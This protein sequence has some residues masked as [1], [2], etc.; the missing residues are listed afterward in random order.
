MRSTS[1]SR[2]ERAIR[3]KLKDDF[4][5]FS[6]KCLKIRTKKGDIQPFQLNKAQKYLHERAQ[7]QLKTL[8]RVRIVI[9]KGR[10]QGISTYVEGRLYWRTI[11]TK[12]VRAFILTHEQGATD[13]LFEMAQRYHELNNPIIKPHTG[14]SNAKEL[15]FDKLDSGYKVG[16][17]GSKAVGRSATIQY[18]HGS[19]VAF[20]P[21]AEEHASGVLQAVP[22][23]DGTEVFL[24]STADGIGNYYH[25]KVMQALGGDDEYELVFIPWFWEPG[26]RLPVPEG[27]ALDD[28]DTD[29]RDLHGLDN[30]QMVW[31]RDKIR[32]F[33]GDAARF[34][35][36]YPATVE[37][38]FAASSDQS[39]I[40]P[41][42]VLAARKCDAEATG[43]LIMGVDVAR[44]GDDSTVYTFRQGR[45]VETQIKKHSQDT[46][47]TAGEI[48]KLINQRNPAKVFVDVIGV[49]AGVVDRL[50]EW[51]GPKIEGI[52]SAE[53]A[54]DSEQY[55][56]RRAEMYGELREW[57]KDKPCQLPDDDR[58][59]NDLCA[60]QY[61]Y[62]SKG[63]Y[64]LE[65]KEDLKK[66]LGR[67]PDMSDS[68]VLTFAE[69]VFSADDDDA[70]PEPTSWMA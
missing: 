9:L 29:Y 23:E 67:S 13:N 46:M 65:A 45:V 40:R 21:H 7:K 3:Q 68:L 24:E 63:Q 35:R 54:L 28:E 30:E 64:Q 47:A 18:F 52:N 42:L 43:P 49:G 15:S 44:F 16:T 1:L 62:T 70:P 17:A 25:K 8:G 33:N 37:E 38:A 22:K 5:H 59:Q 69:P 27:F 56:N 10:Q 31:R 66:R 58:L 55:R 19:E 20:W 6:A 57:L 4:G 32:E 61:K 2:Q 11:H 36:E 26:Y 48:R 34:Q 53:A 39:F 50:K 51:F 12:G 60:V 14:A 41:D